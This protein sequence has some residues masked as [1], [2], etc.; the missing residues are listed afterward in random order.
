MIGNLPRHCEMKSFEL[1]MTRS[2]HHRIGWLLALWGAFLLGG[3]MEPA[4]WET[5]ESSRS[6]INTADVS[7]ADTWP[8]WPLDL[9]FHPLTRLAQ[10]D[11]ERLIEARLEFL[12]EDGWSTRTWGQLRIDLHVEGESGRNLPSMT[13]SIDLENRDRNQLHFDAV[14]RTYL[15][16]L[17]LTEEGLPTR[18]EL[19]AYF[20]SPNGMRMEARTLIRIES[21]TDR[22]GL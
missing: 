16:R 21:R 13:W 18:P 1:N 2:H 12:D 5:S 11:E 4:R 14:T 7:G 8:Y 22:D 19:R 15:F 20:L 6:N 3:C 9:R 17:D 10:L